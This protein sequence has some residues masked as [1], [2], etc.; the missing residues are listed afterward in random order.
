MKKEYHLS[1]KEGIFL[2]CQ[3]EFIYYKCKFKF[4]SLFLQITIKILIFRELYCLFKMIT[5]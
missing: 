5:G 2:E 4:Y 1:E 3:T